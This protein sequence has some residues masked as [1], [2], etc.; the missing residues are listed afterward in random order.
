MRGTA[1]RSRLGS[2]TRPLR[3]LRRLDEVR[4]VSTG[5]RD[6]RRGAFIAEQG[7][8]DHGL[9]QQLT[10]ALTRSEW[11]SF[12]DCDVTALPR[13]R[14]RAT[15]VPVRRRPGCY[16]GVAILSTL[17]TVLT[18]GIAYPWALGLTYRWRAEQHAGAWAQGALHRYRWTS[19]RHLARVAPADPRHPRYLLLLGG[20]PADLMDRPAPRFSLNR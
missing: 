2:P 1:S 16:V 8:V 9:A 7:R 11:A 17:L 13:L 3:E 6:R 20:A 10:S 12:S 14:S 4:S 15:A 5:Q 18:L 19:L